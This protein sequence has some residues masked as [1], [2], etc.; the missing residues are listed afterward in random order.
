MFGQVSNKRGRAGT[1]V[2][3][4]LAVRGAIFMS[5]LL[6]CALTAPAGETNGLYGQV[7]EDRLV[8]HAVK[9]DYLIKIAGMHG[10]ELD[11]LLKQNPPKGKYV[12]IGERFDIFRRTIVPAVIEDGLLVNIPDRTLYIFEDGKLKGHFPVGLGRPDWQ[13]PTGAFSILYKQKDPTWFVPPSI[14]A[15]MKAAGQK[16][17]ETM[18]PMF[19]E[20]NHPESVYRF[21]S[22]G[23]IRM[24]GA[25]VWVLYQVVDVGV[26]GV[27]TY[28]PVKLART[29]SGKVYLEVHKDVYGM[30]GDPL[31]EAVELIEKNR[32]END[33]DWEK[34]VDVVERSDGIA[35]DVTSETSFRTARILGPPE[36]RPSKERSTPGIGVLFR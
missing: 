3:R 10:V 26:E 24:K 6:L 23:C 1:Q 2:G 21:R 16:V 7:V 8:Y 33:V 28:L 27:I 9:G 29:D 5:A 15:E 22:H 18:P 34:V 4:R 31:A 30:D 12:Q 25:D 14:Q 35:Y 36:P 17:I 19:H 13:T 11:Y 20:T 32:L